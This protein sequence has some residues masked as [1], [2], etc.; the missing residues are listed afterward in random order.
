MIQIFVASK[1]S[2]HSYV[3]PR[4]I[5]L[6]KINER[7]WIVLKNPTAADFDK[8][9]LYNIHKLTLEDL[10]SKRTKIKYEEFTTYTYFSQHGLTPTKE[11]YKEFPIHNVDGSRF[12]ITVHYN[13][14]DI[15]DGLILRPDLIKELLIKGVDY[16][17]HKLLDRLVDNFVI[18]KDKS[19]IVLENLEKQIFASSSQKNLM[20]LFEHERKI[21]KVKQLASAN[22]EICIKLTRTGV[23][24]IRSDLLPYFKDI[25]DH[26]SKVEESLEYILTQINNLRDNFMAITSNKINNI[27]KILTL[28]TVFLLPLTFVTSYFGMNINL[29]L[30]LSDNMLYAN[31]IIIISF[32]VMLIDRKSVV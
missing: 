22:E 32:I 21:L 9:K 26:I 13:N 6:P 27:M 15:I 29:P 5:D 2:F 25:H 11:G 10:K 18:I 12:L 14:N 23:K 8:L 7:I 1:T 4:K 20:D 30:S 16:I 17:L 31:G 24:D 28:F 19:F 3:N